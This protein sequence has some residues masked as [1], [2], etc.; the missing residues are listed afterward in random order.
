MAPPKARIPGAKAAASAPK[1]DGRREKRIL[2][3][4][5]RVAAFSLPNVGEFLDLRADAS[6]VAEQR[7]GRP[8]SN[9]AIGIELGRLVL[10]R[11]LVGLTARPVASIF[12]P[13][14]D[15]A[16]VRA[17]AER[18]S[19]ELVEQGKLPL[20]VEL[21]VEAAE[22]AAEDVEA[23]KASARLDAVNDLVW[24]EQEGAVGAY[25][26]EA[27]RSGLDTAEG[28]DWQALN[29]YSTIVMPQVI[30][31]SDAPKAERPRI[32]TLR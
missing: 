10:R 17:K 27:S 22:N 6:L 30:R 12:K 21:I 28:C 24:D 11:N 2:L 18:E 16:A 19:A 7:L 5:N 26:A 9:L 1:A 15:V 4:S 29:D 31:S 13:G 20:D 32:R 3:P 8:P 14:F 23:M 25:L